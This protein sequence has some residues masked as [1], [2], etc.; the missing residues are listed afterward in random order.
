MDYG[1]TPRVTRHR[2]S[3]ARERPVVNGLE[4]RGGRVSVTQC[5]ID[6]E[7][8]E[9]RTTWRFAEGHSTEPPP[10]GKESY[11]GTIRYIERFSKRQGRK[12]MHLFETV[13]W[14][15]LQPLGLPGKRGK[16]V[17]GHN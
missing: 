6:T 7:K 4:I 2:A 1:Y 9:L 14:D 17:F 12:L 13:D 3:T 11:W 15:K 5:C 10:Y 16:V 8:K